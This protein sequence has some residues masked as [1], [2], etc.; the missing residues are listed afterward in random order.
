MGFSLGDLGKVVGAGIGGIGSGSP[1]DEALRGFDDKVLGGDAA[2]AAL[3]AAALQATAGGQAKALFDPFQVLGTS[4]IE[5]AGF[6]T[7]PQ[8]QFD[9]LQSNPLFNLGLE[10]LNQ[11][12]QRSA[13]ASG[14]LGATDTNQQLINNALL[15]ASPLI[16]QQKQSIG[17]LLN[18]GQQTASAQGNLLTGIGAAQAG[19]LVG[20]AN[21][22]QQGI[23]NILQL[24]GALGGAAI[25]APTIPGAGV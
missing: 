7:D 2:D 10:N 21:A 20:A 3:D 24:A 8:Q 4:G 12:T 6:L 19:G 22:Q 18:V 25:G 1:V 16:G 17:D 15:A 23:G 11:Q 14:R 13:A 5:Q 9:F